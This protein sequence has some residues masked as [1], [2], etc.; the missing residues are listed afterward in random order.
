MLG[1]AT[2]TMSMYEPPGLGPG[3]KTRARCPDCEDAP[4]LKHQLMYAGAE[5]DL[6]E[7]SQ[8][9]THWWVRTVADRD[10]ETE[11]GRD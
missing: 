4:I 3:F 10:K 6:L 5:G 9:E 7:C 8:D 2:T 11:N 1:E